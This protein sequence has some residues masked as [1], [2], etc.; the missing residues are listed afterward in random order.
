MP[1]REDINDKLTR[2]FPNEI[3]K[4]G[5][6]DFKRSAGRLVSFLSMQ[7]RKSAVRTRG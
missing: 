3:I 1:L 4:K 2:A 6:L 7:S 5:Y